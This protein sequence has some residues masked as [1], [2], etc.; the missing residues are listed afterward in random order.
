MDDGAMKH[1]NALSIHVGV[2]VGAGSLWSTG[3]YNQLLSVNSLTCLFLIG[4]PH[5]FFK[6]R[7]W[8]EEMC[9]TCQSFDPQIWIFKKKAGFQWTASLGPSS[10]RLQV[11]KAPGQTQG[12]L[13]I[14]D[15]SLYVMKCKEWYSQSTVQI[16]NCVVNADLNPFEA[17]LSI[18]PL[19]RW[20][21]QYC[22]FAQVIRDSCRP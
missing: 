11:F 13:E 19:Q 7:R 12:E 16:C 1:V 9:W 17:S 4:H 10:C 3:G 6:N 15:L 8:V 20:R 22:K 18:F 21:L 14:T 5:Y 2:F